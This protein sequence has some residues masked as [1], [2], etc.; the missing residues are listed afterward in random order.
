MQ[1][2]RS[3]NGRTAHVGLV[4]QPDPVSGNHLTMSHGWSGEPAFVKISS[5]GRPYRIFRYN[6]TV[7]VP[8][9]RAGSP[10]SRVPIKYRPLGNPPVLHPGDV[11]PMEWIVYLRLCLNQARMG[12]GYMVP[13]KGGMGKLTVNYVIRFKRAWNLRNPHNPLDASNGIVGAGVWRALGVIG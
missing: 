5:D 8:A 3:E 10:A 1:P 9:P 4:V 11:M 6:T 2:E 7:K 12:I 13:W